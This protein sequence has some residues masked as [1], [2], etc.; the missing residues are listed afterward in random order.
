MCLYPPV[1]FRASAALPG[2]PAPAI[3]IGG[4]CP[5]SM[6]TW[7]GSGSGTHRRGFDR[8]LGQLCDGTVGAVFAIEASRLARNGRDWAWL[9]VRNTVSI[10]ELFLI[11]RDEQMTR[12]GFE[13]ILHKHV[14]A[15]AVRCPSL[16]FRDWLFE[17]A[18]ACA[19]PSRLAMTDNGGQCRASTRS[20][21]STN[22]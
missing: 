1:Y 3:W 18:V 6:R 16:A 13:Y 4:S 21:A 10:P 12:S 14:Q 17:E 5:G 19:D 9:A 15:A 2:K 22:S 8:L 11:A 7:D 20:R